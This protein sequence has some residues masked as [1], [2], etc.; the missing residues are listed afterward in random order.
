M[1]FEEVL[2][3]ADKDQSGLLQKKKLN[4]PMSVW[5][6]L[7]KHQ[8]EAVVRHHNKSEYLRYSNE[9]PGKRVQLDVTKIRNGAYQFTAI[10]I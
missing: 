1:S 8:V 9:I 2:S 7:H 4:L 3:L 6:V 5:R 10:G